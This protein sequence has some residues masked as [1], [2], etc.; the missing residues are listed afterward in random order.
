[1]NKKPYFSI[2]RGVTRPKFYC[3]ERGC[4]ISALALECSPC[5][6]CCEYVI[7]CLFSNHRQHQLFYLHFGSLLSLRGVFVCLWCVLWIYTPASVYFF[8]EY[9]RGG[10][11]LLWPL[12]S[13]F[14]FWRLA[15]NA[16][17]PCRAVCHA[18]CKKMKKR[19]L[20]L[21]LPQVAAGFMKFYPANT[22]DGCNLRL[23]SYYFHLAITAE[24][25]LE[26]QYYFL[27]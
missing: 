25:A 13:V 26:K 24:D 17:W 7:C 14:A 12:P 22:Q 21:A 11:W 23:N 3:R 8:T 27:F 15:R 1:M 4:G 10:K 16:I 20:A 6:K 19:L 18:A 9:W 2:P 5:V